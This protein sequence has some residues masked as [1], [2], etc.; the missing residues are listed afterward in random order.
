[1]FHERQEEHMRTNVRELT[2]QQ[3][4]DI[5]ATEKMCLLKKQDLQRCKQ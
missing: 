5:T 3:R 2:E 4:R 1:V